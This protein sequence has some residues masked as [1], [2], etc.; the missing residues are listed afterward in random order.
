[1][2]FVDL[3]RPPAACLPPV[4]RTGAPSRTFATTLPTLFGEGR[5][6]AETRAPRRVKLLLEPSRAALP[7][8]PVALDTTAGITARVVVEHRSRENA[9]MARATMV[10]FGTRRWRD[11]SVTSDSSTTAGDSFD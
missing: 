11:V 10:G 4:L 7:A 5:R 2:D 6:L 1:M 9:S 3:S 8:I